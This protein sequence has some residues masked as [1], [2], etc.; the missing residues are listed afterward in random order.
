MTAFFVFPPSV[1]AQFRRGRSLVA[2]AGVGCLGILAGTAALAAEEARRPNV[3]FIF[4]DDHSY[5]TVSCYPEA[6]P[7]ARTPSIDA[8]AKTGVRF[9][10]AYM[11]AWCMPS[12]ASLLTGR[13]PHGIE[14][15][16]MSGKY[17]ASV[18]DPAQCPFWPS[19]LRKAGYHTAHIGKWHTGTDSGF[20]RDWD[21]QIV[22]NRP[23]HPD[24]AGS[25]YED[26][27]LEFDG[28]ERRTPGYST[29]NYTQWACDY[30]KGKNRDAAKPWFLWLCYGAV[31]GPTTPAD[32]HKGAHKKDPVPVPADIFPPR[33][34][35]P[36]YLEETQAWKRGEDGQPYPQK[37]GETFGDNAK[38]GR[39]YADHIHQLL[40][41]VEALDEGVGR[42][43]AALKESGQL[44]NTLVIFTAD[45]GFA[46]G[47]HGFR[48]KLAPYDAN[49]RGP[50]V[51]SMPGTLPQGQVCEKPVNSPDLVA[52]MSSFARLTVPWKLHGRD[53]TP[54]LK[55]PK[56]AVWEHPC[57][58]E[59]T[60]DHFGSD[61]AKVVKANPGQAVH[62]HVPWYA[63]LNDG[64]YKYVRYLAPDV[65][66]ELYD[67]QA[68]PEELTNLAAEPAHRATLLRLRE[69]AVQELD[70]TEA[71]YGKDLPP[72]N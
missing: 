26:Q 45:Q 46:T 4:S 38:K 56:G 20:G 59:G 19:E 14:S 57:F 25:Y 69:T 44:E 2:A 63:A 52:T 55:D 60:G 5:K 61:V 22:W 50:L 64:R 27:I 24:N 15:M 42:V 13:H 37:S 70:R 3:L 51:V 33:P 23:L 1:V 68:D 40:D 72:V 71:G 17:P 35:K 9:T 31:H 39:P 28:K 34:G 12:R 54:L 11:G 47:E 18:Y 7:G 8:L 65:P 36:A 49:Y 6:L 66:E 43:M 21:H 62:H 32:R 48:T 10:H 53:L 16:R 29:D 67:L 58:F 30:I 41:C